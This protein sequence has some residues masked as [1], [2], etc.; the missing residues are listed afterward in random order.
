MGEPQ[1]KNTLDNTLLNI[2]NCTELDKFCDQGLKSDRGRRLYFHLNRVARLFG[3]TEGHIHVC[4]L[5]NRPMGNP[6]GPPR[7]NGGIY[8]STFVSKPQKHLTIYPWTS[9]VCREQNDTNRKYCSAA[10]RCRRTKQ[11]HYWLRIAAFST[12]SIAC[13]QAYSGEWWIHCMQAV[14]T[15]IHESSPQPSKLTWGGPDRGLLVSRLRSV[16]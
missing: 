7:P 1:T 12:E 2:D 3:S 4:S 16:W 10:G 8:S 11:W 6:N 9:L 14:D 15:Y 13:T 5:Y